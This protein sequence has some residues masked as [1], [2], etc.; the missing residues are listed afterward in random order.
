MP[1]APYALLQDLAIASMNVDTMLNSLYEQ[2]LPFRLYADYHRGLTIEELAILSSKP[3]HW[4]KERVEAVRL[5]FERQV[6]IVFPGGCESRCPDR[7]WD[8]QIW[9]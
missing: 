2:N 9:D 8:A 4:I 5:C 7:I 1:A 6:E 3:P